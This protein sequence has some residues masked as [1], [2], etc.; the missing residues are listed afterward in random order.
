MDAATLMPLAVSPA[1]AAAAVGPG[2]ASSWA[3]FTLSF[4]SQ[5]VLW[6]LM[7]RSGAL[8]KTE[9]TAEKAV[10]DAGAA[11]AVAGLTKE[12]SRLA[13]GLEKL[14]EDF[15]EHRLDDREYHTRTD[16]IV[17]Q[18]AIT[19]ATLA[20]T[21]ENQ[22]SQLNNLARDLPLKSASEIPANRPRRR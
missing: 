1:V 7:V 14:S 5:S 20:R 19:D 13:D 4:V 17:K 3:L 6:L 8:R 16:E 11:A 15:Q 12:F 21:V 2:D 9:T 10:A 22:Q 18:Q